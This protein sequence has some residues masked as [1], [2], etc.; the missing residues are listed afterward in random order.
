VADRA[1]TLRRSLRS[2]LRR[3][4]PHDPVSLTDPIERSIA[5]AREQHRLLVEQASVVVAGQI[6]ASARLER[7]IAALERAT[8][9]TQEA[10][11][12]ADQRGQAGDPQG[13]A[14]QHRAAAASARRLVVIE[15]EIDELKRTALDATEASDTA[16][17]A[18][19]R[20]AVLL[21]ARLEERERLLS[22]LDQARFQEQLN[23]TRAQLDR[24]I[25][26]DVPDLHAA[27]RAIDERLATARALAEIRPATINEVRLEL[28]QAQVDRETQAKLDILR[29]PLG[30]HQEDA[31]AVGPTTDLRRPPGLPAAGRTPD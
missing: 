15:Q 4:V 28:D 12:L 6:R 24:P 19:A 30:L 26:E 7:A 9:E 31:G 20:S 3:K 14:I 23:A 8:A 27:R 13:A 11:I 25:G 22:R 29:R 5:E 1:G 18:V 2:F 10:L 21:R 17:A 16:K